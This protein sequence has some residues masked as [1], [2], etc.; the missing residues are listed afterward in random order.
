[1]NN[2]REDV[3]HRA[4][5][6]IIEQ[7]N[8]G[9]AVSMGV[10]KT[11]IG[12]RHMEYIYT[13]TL[14]IL[15]VAP[16]K[17]ILKSW[18]EEAK[19]FNM[20]YLLPHIVFSTYV[21]LNKQD[22]NFDA[23]YLDECHNLLFTHDS[24]LSLYKGKI[25]GLTG[26]P[27]RV[28]SSEKGK[29]VNKYCP[30]KYTYVTDTAVEDGILN[31]YIINVHMLSLDPRKNYM[32][33]LKNG[34]TFGS[35]ELGD[36][37]YWSNRLLESDSP[38]DIQILRIMRMKSLMGYKS[39]EVYAKKLMDNIKDKCIVFANTHEQADALCP[40]SYHS[41]NPD[42]EINLS[43]FK[44]GKIN[45][46]SCVLQLSEGVN[47]PDLKKGIILH[48]YSNERKSAQR[49]GRLLRLNPNETSTIHILCYKDT[50]DETWVKQ[51]LESCDQSKIN[52]I[53]V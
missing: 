3:Q 44:A 35:S 25:V 47:I 6:T 37:N 31:D 20:S 52:Y 4:L 18:E 17:S 27:P 12:L 39:K 15:V 11:L 7:D 9:V 8:V 33:K 48:A 50:I 13:D 32:K 42:S 51:A 36:Y 46:L 21:S 43:D 38:K 2:I 34:K 30:I 22:L 28:S 26:T 5:Q 23:V 45:K 49:I 14:R 1:M 29:M 40:H 16:K 41:S 53:Q 24:W 19:K 10:G